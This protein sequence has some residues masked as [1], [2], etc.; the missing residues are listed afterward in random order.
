MGQSQ[1][2]ELFSLCRKEREMFHLEGKGEI[3]KGR[4]YRGDCIGEIV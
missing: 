1:A 4:L 2:R 3:V